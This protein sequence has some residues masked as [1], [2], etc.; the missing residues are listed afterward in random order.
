MEID[1]SMGGAARV[2]SHLSSNMMAI[3]GPGVPHFP[4]RTEGRPSSMTYLFASKTWP[5]GL[6]LVILGLV[7]G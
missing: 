3:S 6:F 1:I 2:P 4:F 5:G 7:A